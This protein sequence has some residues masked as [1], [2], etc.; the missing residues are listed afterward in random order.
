MRHAVDQLADS[1]LL[2]VASSNKKSQLVTI[3]ISRAEKLGKDAEQA[4]DNKQ[5]FPAASLQSENRF[6]RLPITAHQNDCLKI[7]TS[8]SCAS[9]KGRPQI[10]ISDP[11]LN[12]ELRV[13]LHLRLKVLTV[14]SFVSSCNSSCNGSTLIIC[15]YALKGCHTLSFLMDEKALNIQITGPKV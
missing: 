10:R 8:S 13:H 1:E 15:N 4:V 11:L 3:L 6:F 12:L 2:P 9:I 7:H 14:Q 5:I